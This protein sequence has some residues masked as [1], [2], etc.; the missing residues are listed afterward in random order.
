MSGS[1]IATTV[2]PAPRNSRRVTKRASLSTS[3]TSLPPPGR[4]KGDKDAVAEVRA[5]NARFVIGPQGARCKSAAR[6][7]RV[8]GYHGLR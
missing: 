5:G 4:T 3:N 7:C 1:P 2:A 8:H 6:H